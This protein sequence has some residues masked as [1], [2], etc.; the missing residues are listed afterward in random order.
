MNVLSL[1]DG[2]S[3]GRIA[4]DRLG[5][6]VDKYYASEIDKYATQVSE[7]NYPDIIRLGDVC[8]VKAEDLEPIDLLIA[9]SPCQ[10]FSF[11]GKQLAFDDPRSALFFEFV[12]L[13]KECKPKYF[14]L[15]NVRMKKEFLDII[16]EQVGCEPIFINSALVSAQNRQ[17]FYWT[18]IPGIEQPEQR[19]IVLRDILETDASNEYLAG[20][21]LQKNYKGGN[22][23]NPN[24]KSQ[25]NTIHNDEGKSGTI[26]AGTHGYANGYVKDFDK[27]LD[28]MTN[29]DGKA[30]CLTARYTAAQPENSMQRKQ[31]TMVPVLQ[32]D[33]KSLPLKSQT[34]KAQ[35]AKSSK[36]NFER[37]GT[38][39][40][41][42]IKQEVTHDKPI[43]VGMN[44]EEVK[45][46]KHEV[47]VPNLQHLLKVFKSVSKKTNKQ[48]AEETNLPVTKVEH[49]FR[50]DT[51]FAIPSDDV[52][53]KLK[54]V[55]G[56]TLD[57]FDAQIMEFEYRDG[58]YETKQ[59][60]Y[61]ENGKSP[62]LTAGNSEQ[63]IETHDTP[64]QVGIAVDI[65]GHD[66]I[67]RVYSP[68]GKSSTLTT[69]GGGHR[70]PKVITGGAFR[71][72]AYDTEGK[73]MD[74]DGKSV[75]NKTTQMLELRK[76]AKSNAITTV[77]KDSL[78]VSQGLEFSHGLENGR[79]LEDGKNLSR[80]YSEGS[81]VYKTSGKAATLTAQSKGGKGGH[82]GLYG[83]EV[84]WR[85]L[86][87]LEC[88]RLQT[89]QDD[90]LM[91]VSNT[92]KYKM[93]GN[94]WTIEV[95][96]H[97]FKNMQLAEAGAELSKTN[98]QQTLDL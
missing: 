23:L 5:I 77:G 32:D 52:W 62:T 8:G 26:C 27:N 14:L 19:G 53:F 46:R 83:D 76:D 69:C 86:T 74:K 31:R 11:A 60:V 3:C 17:R 79:R 63:Y 37:S 42:G 88:M 54:E 33:L 48:I 97:I 18:N 2:M 80:N 61:S 21:N 40:A 6:P 82:T 39:H 36:A 87:P 59:R 44:I 24:Y 47:D 30:H 64:K 72:R 84:Y 67:K 75:A 49:W 66:Q 35:Y 93:L 73:R 50:S 4:L 38:Y 20:E 68:D 29:K 22:Q 58:V 55:I 43:K 94:G 34:I 25:A 41:T 89:V 7:A 10:G 71:G 98:I 16:S 9:G 51:S 96:A 95:I 85:K 90:Y 56:I 15:E 78:V 12:R 65:K 13:L 28:K 81:R 70:E 92:Q 45:V 57:T 91:P 1:F